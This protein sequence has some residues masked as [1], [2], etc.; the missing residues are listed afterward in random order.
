MLNK[1]RA[2]LQYLL[3]KRLLSRLIGYFA[4]KHYGYLTHWVIK[5]FI[6]FY[7]VDMSE[8][9]ESDP[10]Y[11]DTF[12]EFFTR[13]LRADARPISKNAKT[14]VYPSDGRISQKGI[15][16]FGRIIQAKGH[17][18]YVYELL[19]G[20]TELAKEFDHGKFITFYLS[21][22]DYHRVH[23]PVDGT[24]RQMFHVPGE[25]FSVN[26]DT[27]SYIPKLFAHNER[28]ITIFDTEVG[29]IAI[30]LVGAAIV[31]SIETVWGGIVTPA[32]KKIQ[33]WQYQ[34]QTPPIQ[35]D[36]GDEM[37]RFKIGSTVILLFRRHAINF[38]H[39]FRQNQIIKMGTP[40]ATYQ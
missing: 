16:D 3:P 14:L 17:D 37:G 33:Q 22:R 6:H 2:N 23:M 10:T 29:T 40:M 31:A 21:P 19:G 1:W 30:V 9:Q 13:A 8:S 12:N 7:Q 15:I 24:L 39:S 25:L 4:D 34:C 38:I 5:R 18:Y 27:S 11:F 32:G 36:K 20:N 35:L 28:V 26:P